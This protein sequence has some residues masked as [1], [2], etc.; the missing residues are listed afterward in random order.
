MNSVKFTPTQVEAIRSGTNPG[1]TMVVGPPG[2]GKTDVA[3]QIISNLYHNF[4]NQ[5]IL[6]VTHSNQALNQLFEKIIALDVDERH[7]L[8]L[9]HGEEA[10]ETEKDFSRYGRVNYVLA[11]R[12]ELLEEVSKLQKSL[13]VV[14]DVSY[15]C[16]TARYFFLYQVQSRWE[17]Y[18]AKIEETKDP[19][20]SMIADLFPFNVFFRPA[21][22]P[23]PLFEGK[24]FAEDFE[25]A[26][27][28][29]RYI[30]DIF[31][32]LDEFWAFELLRSGLDRTRY[33]C[34]KEA[35][36]VAMTCTHAA[37][38]RHELVKLGFKY[39][40]ILMEESAQILEIETFIPLLLQNPEDGSN[41]LKR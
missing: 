14:G 37:L 41:R 33:L 23:N 39:D 18:M 35:K 12:L 7:L 16:E 4:P 20:I 5:R 22:A 8:R 2:T 29:W 25:T 15:T 32:Q 1:L 6:I 3:V 31:T 34:V 10:L 26:Q 27:S 30:Q 17:E 13:G 19:S 21:K 11:K 40:S 9:G 28:C 38:K 36:I 24:D